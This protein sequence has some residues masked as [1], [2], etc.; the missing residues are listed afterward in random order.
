MLVQGIHNISDRAQGP[1]VA[2]NC[3]ALPENLLESE[4]FGYVDGAFTGAKRGGR[5]GMF[6]LAHGGTL[7]LDEIGEMPLSLQS[8][9]LRVLQEREVSG[10]NA[11]CS[12]IPAPG[13][14]PPCC[15]PANS[16]CPVSPAPAWP[17]TA[18]PCAGRP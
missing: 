6:E 5:Q 16:G 14:R 18:G 2:L 10:Q 13:Y 11:G 3:A 9:I 1:F 17:D 7:F 15:S 12:D 8:R 4:L